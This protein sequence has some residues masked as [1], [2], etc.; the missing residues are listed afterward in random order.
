MMDESEEIQRVVPVAYHQPAEVLEPGEQALEPPATRS[1]TGSDAETGMRNFSRAAHR[2]GTPA[3][4]TM[5]ARI[6]RATE[7]S[8]VNSTRSPWGH[9]SVRT[10]TA[11]WSGRSMPRWQVISVSLAVLV[12]VNGPVLSAPAGRAWAPVAP[13]AVPPYD[14]MPSGMLAVD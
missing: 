7:G 6:S 13:L 10:V 9:A 14:Y 5:C 12:A 3:S 1:R 4:G 2:G 11:A 8:S